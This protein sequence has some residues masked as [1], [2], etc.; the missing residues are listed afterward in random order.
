MEGATMTNKE[1]YAI[2]IQRFRTLGGVA[3]AYCR[4]HNLSYSKFKYYRSQENATEF[5]GDK[6]EKASFVELTGGTGDGMFMITL[7]G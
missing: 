4:K 2:H 6:V 7:N 1:K 3:A 5:R